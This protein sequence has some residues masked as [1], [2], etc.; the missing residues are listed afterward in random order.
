MGNA[1]HWSWSVTLLSLKRWLAGAFACTHA[2]RQDVVGLQ[3][4][5]A[6]MLHDCKG[7]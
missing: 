5:V 3:H 4:M 2:L 7:W 6:V 1:S